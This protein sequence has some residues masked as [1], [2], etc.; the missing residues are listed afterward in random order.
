LHC[1][2]NP[3]AQFAPAQKFASFRTFVACLEVEKSAKKVRKKVEKSAKMS[4]GFERF[5]CFT[6]DP[7]EKKLSS[8]FAVANRAET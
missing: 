8:D 6:P 2:I 7:A 3:R 1:N 5:Q 4:A